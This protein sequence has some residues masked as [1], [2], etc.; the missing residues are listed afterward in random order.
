MNSFRIIIAD[1]Q[2][3][4][5]EDLERALLRLMPSATIYLV[6]SGKEIHE[7]LKSK[8]IELI[9]L[10]M[11]YPEKDGIDIARSIRKENDQV[12][13]IAVTLKN[14]KATLK[15]ITDAGANGYVNKDIE[16][17]MLELAI[18]KVISN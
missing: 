15:Q 8:F 10:D 2:P 14:D 18:G 11:R 1:D 17:N 12:K 5:R 16:Q 4:F 13:I 9:F 3:A 7:L 6:S